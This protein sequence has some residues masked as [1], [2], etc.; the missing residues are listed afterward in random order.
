M[1]IFWSFNVH[2]CLYACVAYK[3]VEIHGNPWKSVEKSVENPWNPWTKAT[4]AYYVILVFVCV[5]VSQG[6]HSPLYARTAI[7]VCSARFFRA[8]CNNPLRAN[9]LPV[10]KDLL[11]RSGPNLSPLRQC[12]TKAHKQV[13]VWWSRELL[14]MPLHVANVGLFF[15]MPLKVRKE[16]KKK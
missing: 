6:P 2:A 13:T 12:T 9:P 1:S 14:T 16:A 15:P 3:S 10:P 8:P 7:G 5:C 4:K 11:Q